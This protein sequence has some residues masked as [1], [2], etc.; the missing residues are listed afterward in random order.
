MHGDRH[1]P[2]NSSALSPLYGP[3]AFSRHP[4]MIDR[5]AGDSLT[6]GRALAGRGRHPNL[7]RRIRW[8]CRT[9]VRIRL[10]KTW[11]TQSGNRFSA[12]SN[13]QQRS[14]SSSS[15]GIGGMSCHVEWRMGL[16][17][18]IVAYLYGLGRSDNRLGTEGAQS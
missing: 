5:V 18:T 10:T 7:N 17:G 1:R 12:D 6:R 11:F 3:V 16:Q 13:F 14:I 9:D 2:S 15:R 4:R 8:R